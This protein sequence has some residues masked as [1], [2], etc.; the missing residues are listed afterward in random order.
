[1]K[2]EEILKKAIERAELNGYRFWNVRPELIELSDEGY[3]RYK[4]GKSYYAGVYETIFDLDF[5]KAFWGTEKIGVSGYLYSDVIQGVNNEI[6][7]EAWQFH[8]QQMVLEE[9]PIKYLEKFL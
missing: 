7:L 1:V 5:A 3:W 2:N 8:L 4:N 9:E 6:N